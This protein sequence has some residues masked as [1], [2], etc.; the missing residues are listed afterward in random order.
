MAL[1]LK[2]GT[3][4]KTG[5]DYQQ[6]LQTHPI[7]GSVATSKSVSGEKIAESLE[8]TET[9][10]PGVFSNGMSITVEGGRVLN[11][12]NYETARVG[13]TLT[14]PCDKASLEEAYAYATNWVSD[15]IEEAIKLAKE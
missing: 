15:K 3:T 9:I 8:S 2:T 10:H 4:P 11:L 5:V 6:H 12:G 13:V 1:N 7:V 14:V